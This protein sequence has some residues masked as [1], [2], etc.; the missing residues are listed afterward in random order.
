MDLHK[1]KFLNELRRRAFVGTPIEKVLRKVAAG[2][3][4]K[5]WRFKLLPNHDLFPYPSIRTIQR[6]DRQLELNI[7]EWLEWSVYFAV[8]DPTA[9]EI[10][11]LLRPGDVAID[12]GCNIGSILSCISKSVGESGQVIGFEA[13]LGRFKKCRERIAFEN[14]KNAQLVHCALSDQAGEVVLSSPDPANLG[15]TRVNLASA[16]GESAT[17]IR[18]DH[19]RDKTNLQK[20]NFIKIDV[21]GYELKVL[22]GMEK[23]IKEQRPILFIEIDDDNLRE[24]GHSAQQLISH[25]TQL[26][27]T[28]SLSSGRP[29]A[30]P[31][32]PHFDLLA[33][34]R[35]QNTK[36]ESVHGRS[37]NSPRLHRDKRY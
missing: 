22:R 20:I 35:P 16:A 4:E 30:D 5:S 9:K 36:C 17:A 2:A 31:M 13:S 10:E 37:K 24:Q 18:F 25:I 19:W 29:L 28:V 7:G 15:R 23:T 27:Y 33:T 3:E 21:E 34:P 8:T 1:T 11:K 12:V 32:P 14:I 26:D 6:D